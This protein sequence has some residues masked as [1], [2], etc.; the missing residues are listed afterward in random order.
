MFTRTLSEAKTM[1]RPCG[2]MRF[3]AGELGLVQNENSSDDQS[4]PRVPRIISS[5]PTAFRCFRPAG[6]FIGFGWATIP[7]ESSR[8]DLRVRRVSGASPRPAFWFRDRDFTGVMAARCLKVTILRVADD[9]DNA[10][11]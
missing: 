7:F 4:H 8:S 11:M 9:S 2:G 1:R 6:T 3:S 10:P 5:L